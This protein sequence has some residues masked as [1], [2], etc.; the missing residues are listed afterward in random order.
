MYKIYCCILQGRVLLLWYYRK[1]KT[2]RPRMSNIYISNNERYL[3]PE[4]YRNENTEV[5]NTKR[6]HI[7]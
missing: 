6:N 3:I 7:V 1:W 4:P 2:G 5:G